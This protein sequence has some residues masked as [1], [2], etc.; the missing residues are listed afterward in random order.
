MESFKT[1]IT[2]RRKE[3][4]MTQKV[5]AEKLNVSD[6]TI[7]K[8]ETG[9]SY[10]EITLLPK[11]AQI[12]QIDIAELLGA[13]DLHR[14]DEQELTEEYDYDRIQKYKTGVFI[15]IALFLAGF[16]FF[17]MSSLHIVFIVLCSLFIIGSLLI[18]SIYHSNFRTFYRDKYYTKAYDQA[19][20]R[21][22]NL[23]A[24]ALTFLL[25]LLPFVIASYSFFILW[26]IPL[27]LGL[28]VFSYFTVK[29]AHLKIHL[30]RVN[31]ILLVIY[32][33]LYLAISG[34]SI[35]FLIDGIFLNTK[36]I[37]IQYTGFYL[38]QVFFFFFLRRSRYEKE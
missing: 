36:T 16:L 23:Y 10:P 37:L 27:F 13:E 12:L 25:L 14:H 32:G 15:A 7:S 5:L 2:H 19:Y 17:I 31:I 30:D 4:Q 35:L 20:A 21:Y 11:L 18:F 26:P 33:L 22:V 28:S 8:W 1:I 38:N 29:K 24:F 3:L 6:K 9:G 34:L